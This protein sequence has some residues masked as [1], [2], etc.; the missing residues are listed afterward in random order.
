MNNKGISLIEV[1]VVG[2]IA[3]ILISL[4]LKDSSDNAHHKEQRLRCQS[5][6]LPH[7]VKEFNYRTSYCT[8]DL[9][10][11]QVQIGN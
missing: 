4:A 7:G 3:G 9:S 2:A 11:K 8:C 6:C 10:V 5:S 1:M